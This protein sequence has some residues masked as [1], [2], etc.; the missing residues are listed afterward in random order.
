MCG[1]AGFI[2][3]GDSKTLSSMVR[4]LKHRGPDDTGVWLDGVVGLGHARL[5]IIDLSPA[6]HQPMHSR[7][8]KCTVV[9]NGEIYNYKEL[10]K[11]LEEKGV[12]FV[13]ES[14]TEVLLA[15]YEAYGLE[16]F[17]RLDGMFA[18]A[19]YDHE[20]K[21]LV[22]ARDRMGEKPLH[23]A[24]F[25]DAFI[26][27]S[28]PKALFEHTSV[29]RALDADSTASYLTFD[30]VLTPR[31]I[32]SGVSKLPPATY[33]VYS[34]GLLTTHVYWHPPK[35]GEGGLSFDS[36]LKRLDSLFENSVR[37]QLVAD[38]PV[39]VFLS[40]GLDSSLVAYYATRASKSPVHTFSLGFK[41]ASYDESS[42]AKEVATALG[43]IHHERIVS[44]QEVR[45]ALP[46]LSR[47][48]DEPIADPALLANY[49]LS[50]FAREHVTVALGGD[51]SDELFAGYPTFTAEKYLAWYLIIP[52]LIRRN[53]IEPV[54]RALP[55]SHTYFSFDFKAKQFLR[56]ANAKEPY[57]HQAWLSSFSEQERKEILTASF[58]S[59]IHTDPLVR[60]DEYLAEVPKKNTHMR[61]TYFY[62]RTYLLDV[63][64]A[65]VDRASMQC[66]LEVR[67]PY[68][69][70]EIV[71]FA[72]LLPESF[73]QQ[74]SVGKY[75]LRKLMHGKL[76]P[77][78]V[79]R[80]K[81]GFGLPVGEWFRGEWQEL[82]RET[83]SMEKLERQGIFL[84]DVVERLIEEHVQGSHNHRK[85]LWSL[86]MFQLWHDEWLSV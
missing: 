10:K 29:A 65:K 27:A 6:G 26:F 5:S 1:I 55:V 81:H 32:Y 41:E 71:E 8:K 66:S 68:L 35:E 28:E 31:S 56:G 82:L 20:Q 3:S 45:D 58:Q 33:A 39:G 48:L 86:L 69:D 47:S 17:S 4:T 54:V 85:K 63:I 9:F 43:T 21:A 36:A 72:L 83:L 25:K 34:E 64:L 53:V 62:L 24:S 60:I 15:M 59:R 57:I 84:P 49:L 22:I 52:A 37:K 2:G 19:L 46:E 18:V 70:K 77:T 12:P 30:A 11:E 23:F 50:K 7:S 76:P 42:Y 16:C 79:T 80:G 44:A 40:G 78:A 75:I 38:V 73:K 13:S 61:A 74:G 67:A 51:G 14:D